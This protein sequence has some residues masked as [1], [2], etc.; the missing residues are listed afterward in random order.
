MTGLKEK[1]QKEIVPE[2]KKEFELKNSLECPKVKK[3]VLNVGIGNWVTKD[4]SRK[5]EVLKKVSEDLKM[6]TGQ[7]PQPAPAKK[8]I[9]GFSVREGTPV[10]LKVTLR[11]DR[12]YNFID[13]LVH[14]VFPR[15]RDFQGVKRTSVDKSGNLTIGLKEQVVFPEIYADDTDF[16][17]GVEVT[18][19]TSAKNKE[20]G[21]AL[22]NKMGIPFQKEQTV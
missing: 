13:R 12:M 5:E 19:T 10:G 21:V 6:I 18:I 1:Y 22:L 2:L 17:F 11:R 9:S 14:I 8:S 7:K 15:V 16:F 4:A 3:V 20:E